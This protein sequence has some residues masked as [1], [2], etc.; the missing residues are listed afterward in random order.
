[1]APFSEWLDDMHDD[2]RITREVEIEATPADVWEALATEGGR[3]RWLEPDPER[4]LHVELADEPE[5]IVWWWWH[6]NEP[7]RRVELLIT[8]VPAG[9]RVIVVESA[10]SF[11]LAQLAAAFTAA[12][13]GVPVLA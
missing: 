5:R 2:A 12:L 1:M 13:T 10:P 4:E 3:E 11:P 6:E 9:T 7:P 8:A